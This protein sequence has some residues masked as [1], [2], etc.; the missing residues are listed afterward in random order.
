VP[1]VGRRGDVRHAG[2]PIVH[3]RRCD[4]HNRRQ[5]PDQ[6]ERTDQRRH[7]GARRLARIANG[8]LDSLG[9]IAVDARGDIDVSGLNGW[10]IWQIV[11]GIAH[12]VGTRKQWLARQSGGDYSVLERA[13]DGVV[14]GEDGSL[15]LRVDGHRLVVSEKFGQQ[16]AHEYFWLTYFAF[17]RTESSTRTSFLVAAPS[18][19]ANS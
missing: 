2:H 15:L 19:L 17:A 3:P 12:Q 7:P 6:Q 11:H 5:R 18:N 13:P 14:Y 4:P 8:H 10:A 1:A 16:I 9:P